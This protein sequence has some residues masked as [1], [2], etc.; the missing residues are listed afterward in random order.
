M[1]SPSKSG[2]RHF[3]STLGAVLV[4]MFPHLLVSNGL[5]ECVAPPAGLVSW[6]RGETNALDHA[7]TNHGTLAGNTNYVN[8]LV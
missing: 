2:R 3:N 4:A 6:W 7:G 8:R 5:A 1:K